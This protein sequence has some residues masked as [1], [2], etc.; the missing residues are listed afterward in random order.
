MPEPDPELLAT[1]RAALADPD[2]GRQSCAPYDVVDAVDAALLLAWEKAE[3]SG[4][5]ALRPRLAGRRGSAGGHRARGRTATRRRADPVA[6]RTRGRPQW[7]AR[8]RRYHFFRSAGP[9]P[10]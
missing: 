7:E 5:R 1:I 6:K 8:S 10:T 9:C 3:G 2:P 4:Y